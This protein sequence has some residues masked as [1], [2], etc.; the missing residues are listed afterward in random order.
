MAK[1]T[2]KRIFT[3]SN[4]NINKRQKKRQKIRKVIDF[5]LK[6]AKIIQTLRRKKKLN[7]L[8]GLFF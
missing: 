4:I 3:K 1:K 6:C 5:Q 2:N 7:F 8:V